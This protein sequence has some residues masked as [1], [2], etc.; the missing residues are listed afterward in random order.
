MHALES[1]SFHRSTSS[2]SNTLVS[3]AKSTSDS[4]TLSNHSEWTKWLDVTASLQMFGDGEKIARTIQQ[5]VWEKL[6]LTV[7]I[8]VAAMIPSPDNKIEEI[9]RHSDRELRKAKDTGKNKLSYTFPN[10]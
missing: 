5:M 3:Y 9:I 2:M 6:G 1:F 8:G 7:S 4:R 10:K